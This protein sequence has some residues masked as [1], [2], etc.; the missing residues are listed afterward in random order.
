MASRFENYETTEIG[1]LLTSII[2]LPEMIPEYCALSRVG[3]PAVQAV[4]ADV[5]PII[6][7]LS[8]KEERDAASQFVGWRVAKVMRG[9]GY[10]LIQERGRV[11]G[12]P[13]RTGA[14]WSYAPGQVKVALSIPEGI[15]RTVQVLV[16]AKDDG[17]VVASVD[18]K[19]GD[20]G[21]VR[22]M[23]TILRQ[24][25]VFEGAIEFATT[26]AERHGYGYVHVIDGDRRLPADALRKLL[27]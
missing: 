7:S 18:A 22:S 11:T 15:T 25:V 16:R 17:E 2:T 19:D 24:D 8:T 6:E 20:L 21:S 14:V 1:A 27:S 12:A 13:Y 26:Y 23:R 9:L 3:K 4:G 10:A 5:A